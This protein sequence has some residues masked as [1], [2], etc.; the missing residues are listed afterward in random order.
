MEQLI[1]AFHVI[2]YLIGG[3]YAFLFKKNWLDFLYVSIF[4]LV[5]LSWTL[6]KGECIISYV[7]K[8]RKDPTYQMGDDTSPED[9]SSLFG[10]NTAF[11]L[12]FSPFFFVLQVF[13]IY[14]VLKR[15][16][17]QT[18]YALLFLVYPVGLKLTNHFLYQGFFSLVFLSAVIQIIKKIPK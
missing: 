10:K 16:Q 7:L 9:L 11:F 1:L 18:F 12:N 14:L 15:N 13:N 3:F 2:I 4:F 6:F 5:G 8:K 17:L